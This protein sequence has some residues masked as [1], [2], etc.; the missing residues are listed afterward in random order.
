MNL[1][2]KCAEN[3]IIFK[4]KQFEGPCMP[5]FRNTI[6]SHHIPKLLLK[7]GVQSLLSLVWPKNTLFWSKTASQEKLTEKCRFWPFRVR[8]QNYF[9]SWFVDVVPFLA[10]F[11]SLSTIKCLLNKQNNM[12]QKCKILWKGQNSAKKFVILKKKIVW[13]ALYAPF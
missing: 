4:K 13:G 11:L 8:V 2:G 3:L 12:L 9:F 5:L 1:L 6:K 7:N 10:T